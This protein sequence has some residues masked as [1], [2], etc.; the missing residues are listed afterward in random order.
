MVDY[1]VVGLGLAGVSFCHTL[2]KANRSFVVFNDSSQRSSWVA[3]GIYNPLVLKRFKVSWRATEQIKLLKPF[4]DSLSDNLDITI[5]HP[6]PVLRRL[7]SAEE[8]NMWFEAADKPDLAPFMKTDLYEYQNPLIDAPFGF[9]M[10][11]GT[12]RINTKLLV[13][14]YEAYSM[15]SGNLVRESLDPDRLEVIPK[16]VVYGSIKARRIVF[17]TGFGLS[18]NPYF[19]YLPLPG[20]KG[21]LLTIRAT[22]LHEK[23]LIKSSVFLIPTGED[24]YRVGAT[25]KW[26]DKTNTPTQEAKDELLGQLDK[27]LKCPYE[28]V[29]HIA[30]IRPTVT[31]RRPLVGRHPVYDNFYVLN[32]FGSRGVMI[33]PYA[34]KHLFNYIEHGEALPEDMDIRR[35]DHKY[36]VAD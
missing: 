1:L 9:G 25:Y 14:T 36:T 4:Y 10:V 28:V 29:D 17:C 32:G 11:K 24:L 6:V 18:E 30:G 5:D 15:E 19:N 27:F 12:G 7:A 31:D 22:E 26:K 20:T 16:G 13:E 33:A 34:S 23:H 35:F 8:Q 2:E 3:G 21:E